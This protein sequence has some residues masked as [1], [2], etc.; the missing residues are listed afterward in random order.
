M[1]RGTGRQATTGPGRSPLPPA[2]SLKRCEQ[3]MLPSPTCAR[4]TATPGRA[5]RQ[6]YTPGRV[7]A[8]G[9]KRPKAAR[10]RRLS[11]LAAGASAAGGDR[12]CELRSAPG[13]LAINGQQRRVRASCGLSRTSSRFRISQVPSNRPRSPR[14]NRT[15]LGWREQAPQPLKLLLAGAED[16]RVAALGTREGLVEEEPTSHHNRS[17]AFINVSRIYNR[18]SADVVHPPM[19]RGIAATI[20]RGT[21]VRRLHAEPLTDSPPVLGHIPLMS[22]A[23][24]RPW[25]GSAQRRTGQSGSLRLTWFG[26][27]YAA[28]RAG[29]GAILDCSV[30]VLVACGSDV[31]AS[32]R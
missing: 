30:S 15:H 25:R 28:R 26:A 13:F 7:G 5:L 9:Q 14:A 4:P 1:K 6:S 29:V 21:L 22:R 11:R 31:D 19:G 12:T 27:A 2:G 16:K 18:A 23:P 32:L 20:D 10:S 8:N 3:C 24:K 17:C